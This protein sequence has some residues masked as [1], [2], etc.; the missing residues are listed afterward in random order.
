MGMVKKLAKKNWL[1]WFML[2]GS[3]LWGCAVQHAADKET[4]DTDV[5]QTQ[6]NGDASF[7]FHVSAEDLEQWEGKRVYVAVF[8]NDSFDGLDGDPIGHRRVAL[9]TGTI[10]GGGFSLVCP[11]ALQSTWAYPS[12]AVFVDVDGD[13]L[14]GN[15]DVGVHAQR[16]G[17]DSDVNEQVTAF[18][19]VAA[20]E[21]ATGPLKPPAGSSASSFCEGY[22]YP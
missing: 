19:S 16:Y 1:G 15:Q 4:V 18:S 5:L 17:W 20:Q 2:S 11:R 21:G 9:L 6:C 3:M 7:D 12:W 13:G 8:E 14:C 10:A 22:F